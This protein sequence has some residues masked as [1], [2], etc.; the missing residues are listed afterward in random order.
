[1]AS[2]SRARR[3]FG[4]ASTAFA[5][6]AALI[7]AAAVPAAAVDY[8]APGGIY[9]PFTNCPL[10]NPLMDLSVGGAATGCIASVS[11]SG[12]FSIH[13]IP[14]PVTHAVTVQFGV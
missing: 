1:M 12:T 5:A 4:A 7:I 14:V 8:P 2:T 10:T 3:R 11:T 9:T 13:G 6:A